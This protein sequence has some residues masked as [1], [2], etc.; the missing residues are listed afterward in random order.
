MA[1]PAGFFSTSWMV[2]RCSSRCA[3]PGRPR[4]LLPVRPALT[5]TRQK[6]SYQPR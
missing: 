1:L 2:T 6:D 5:R 4:R 3:R